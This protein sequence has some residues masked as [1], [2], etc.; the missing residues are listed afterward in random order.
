[1]GGLDLATLVGFSGIPV[2]TALVQL[3]KLTFPSLDARWWPALSFGVA[4]G[5]NVAVGQ[6]LRQPLDAGIAWGLLAGLSAS[7]LYTWTRQ[8]TGPPAAGEASRSSG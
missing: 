8:R 4:L 3:V 5:L 6:A 2:V 7:G 1:V